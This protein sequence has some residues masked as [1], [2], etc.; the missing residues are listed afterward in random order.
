[1]NAVNVVVMVH[2][3]KLQLYLLEHLMLQV[4]LKLYM[5]LVVQLLASSL[6]YPVLL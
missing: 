2:H 3:V 5:I 6:T 4:L 1:M